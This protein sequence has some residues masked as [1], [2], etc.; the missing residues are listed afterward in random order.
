[1]DLRRE[2]KAYTRACEHLLSLN[3]QLTDEERDL[4]E[5]YLNELSLGNISQISRLCECDTQRQRQSNHRPRNPT[6]LPFLPP[7]VHCRASELRLPTNNFFSCP[8]KSLSLVM[9]LYFFPPLTCLK[10]TCK[11]RFSE[12]T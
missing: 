12:T 6:S 8:S 10:G 1:M 7:H 5:Y 3:E 2:I 11:E 9:I 4:L